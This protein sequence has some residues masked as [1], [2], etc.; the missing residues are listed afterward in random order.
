MIN[1][2]VNKCNAVIVGLFI[3]CLMALGPARAFAD[4]L[5]ELPRDLEIG[6]AL[7]ALPEALQSEATIYVRDPEKG[8]IRHR[9][10]TNGFTT[11]VARTSIRFYEADWK[12]T[13][14]SDILIPIAFDQV[15]FEHHIIP[16]FAVEHMRI[17]G[18]APEKAKQTLRQRFSDGTYKA[19]K[20]GG[21]SYMYSPIHRAY[22]EPA[23]SNIIMTVSFPHHM[24]YAPNIIAK[25]MGAMDPHGRAGILD[26]GGKDSGPHGYFYFMVAPDQ[27]ETLRI[28]Y[29]DMLK[30]L[31]DV[32]ANWCLPK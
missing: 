5:V 15:G 27:A 13:Y 17:N 32:H 31:C 28:K 23:K 4:Y 26:H 29:A 25:D 24:P 30:R 10:G 20:K 9:K 19:P 21:M 18:V 11:F 14:P 7:S 12:Y 8:F 2:R 6:L 3:L 1:S 22:M 16:Y